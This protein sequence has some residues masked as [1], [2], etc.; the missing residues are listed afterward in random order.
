MTSSD[1]INVRQSV[2]FIDP[3]LVLVRRL[4]ITALIAAVG[5][6]VFSTA[7]QG[8]CPGGVR[9]DGT[10]IDRLGN[11]T[12]VVPACITMTLRP[13]PLVYLVLA[14]IVARAVTRAVQVERDEA[15]RVLGRAGPTVIIT[16]VF[17]VV[18]TMAA[19]FSI[20]L[21]SWDGATAPPIPGW[22][23]IDVVIT[24]MQGA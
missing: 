9:A 10:L 7:S 15:L 5:Y 20:S 12:E 16:T 18:L 19:F 22:L 17:A 21:E 23:V 4:I 13:S 2:V 11:P 6:S 8:Y 24:P 14:L 1:T 3:V